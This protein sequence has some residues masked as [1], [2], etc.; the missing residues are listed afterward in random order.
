[1]RL[2]TNPGTN[3]SP[4]VIAAHDI[5]VLPQ[6]IVVDDVHHDTRAGVT[7]ESVDGW[8]SGANVHPYVLGTSAAQFAGHL[9]RLGAADPE[10]LVIMSSRKIIQS[11]AACI[12]A[13]KTLEQHPKWKHLQVRV[14][15]TGGTD[16]G[17]GLVATY[18]AEAIAAGFSL[19]EVFRL[20]EAFSAAT[21]V[22][23]AVQEM[24]N[25]VKG[26]RASFLK[27]WAAKFLRVRPLIAFV[28]GQLESVR[29][30]KAKTEPT[31]VLRDWALDELGESAR[32][33][34][35]VG[36][37][38]GGVPEQAEVLADDLESR[39]DVRRRLVLPVVPSIYLHGGPGSVLVAVT[40]LDRLDWV[41]GD[42]TAPADT[43][44]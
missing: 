5:E 12:T 33:R 28:D 15:D 30:Y 3:M 9:S 37:S 22:A 20:C 31:E 8:I 17:A 35:W 40:D 21:I 13:C 34:V 38:H 4:S 26:G 14:V 10:L 25:L 18:A 24:D 11:Y 32:R 43:G 29:N 27:V 16:V 7:L 44:R 19:D 42:V 6:H 41:P 39:L 23:F 36:V 2:V 1:M